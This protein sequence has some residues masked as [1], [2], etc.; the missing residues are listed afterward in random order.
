MILYILNIVVRVNDLCEKLLKLFDHIEILVYQGLIKSFHL[1]L[2]I[3]SLLGLP[4]LQCYPTSFPH[5]ILDELWHRHMLWL[6]PHAVC[7]FLRKLHSLIVPWLCELDVHCLSSLSK[8]EQEELYCFHVFCVDFS[9]KL[10]WGRFFLCFYN[11]DLYKPN[12]NTN[13]LK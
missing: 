9:L 8:S 4:E 2:L 12:I 7:K 13:P 1:F 5:Q 11:L 3:E 6:Y 10:L